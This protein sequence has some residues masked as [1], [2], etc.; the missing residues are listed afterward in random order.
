VVIAVMAGIAAGMSFAVAGLAQQHSAQSKAARASPSVGL[1][2]ELARD[3]IWLA[4][5]GMAV[6]AYGFQSLALAYGSLA[7]V[8]PLITTEILFAV[9]LS[10]AL[11]RLRPGPREWSGVVAVTAGLAVAIVASHPRA[12]DANPAARQ[13]A[14][15]LGIMLVVVAAALAWGRAVTG[16]ARAGLYAAAA[17]SVLGVQSAFLTAVVHQFEQ[18]IST[19]FRSWQAYALVVASAAGLLLI[20]SAFH[21][22][23]LAVVLPVVNACE[24]AMAIG[25]GLGLFGDQITLTAG[26]LAA[27][28]AGLCLLVTGIALLGGSPLIRLLHGP[29]SPAGPGSPADPPRPGSP[30]DPA[31]PGRPA[32]PAGPGWPAD[33][34]VPDDRGRRADG[35][36]AEAPAGSA[37]GS[38][39]GSRG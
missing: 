6:V 24:P 14:V 21:S 15:A 38:L 27:A 33:L 25:L 37:T 16:P 32:D 13:W 9:P 19:P 31:G 4:G 36:R 17:A 20:Q 7:L 10:I 34:A 29:P 8:Q 11:H 18:G 23:P 12:G 22:G 28:L 5:I 39:T 1:L 3:R 35:E 2:A 30:A 26:H